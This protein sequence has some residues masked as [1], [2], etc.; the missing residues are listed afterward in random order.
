M[1]TTLTGLLLALAVIVVPLGLAGLLIEWRAR[2]LLPF[3]NSRT[4][5]AVGGTTALSSNPDRPAT[6][7]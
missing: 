5:G 1:D 2:K 3:K 7:N 4:T 6:G